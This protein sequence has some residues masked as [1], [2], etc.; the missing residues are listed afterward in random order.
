M[1]LEQGLGAAWVIQ[2]RKAFS[3]L[4]KHFFFNGMSSTY[5]TP[6]AQPH[7]G[8]IVRGPVQLGNTASKSSSH[9]CIY[10][11]TPSTFTPNPVSGSLPLSV[12]A[13]CTDSL[14]EHRSL[15]WVHTLRIPCTL[16]T[17]THRSP[18][19]TEPESYESFQIQ[20]VSVCYNRISQT[21]WLPNNGNSF[22]TVLEA[23]SPRSRQIQRLVRAHVPVHRGPS[24]HCIL[25][26]QMG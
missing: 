20:G 14:R 23:R 15:R 13:P 6:V 10:F 24:S 1:I 25:T 2:Y 19:R 18:S 26:R 5:F 16:D 7:G 4:K 3:N 12:L 8:N 22:L 21:K 11:C 9:I 17:D